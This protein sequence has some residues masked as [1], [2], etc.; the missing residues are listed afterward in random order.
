MLKLSFCLFVILIV[1]WMLHAK[2]VSLVLNLGYVCNVIFEATLYSM[3]MLIRM[4]WVNKQSQIKFLG[5]LQLYPHKQNLYIFMFKV[6]Y[7]YLFMYCSYGMFPDKH[8]WGSIRLTPRLSWAPSLTRWIL[9]LLFQ[10]LL[11]ALLGSGPSRS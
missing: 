9:I 11:I 3:Y 1:S 5:T 4:E 10:A 2:I 8:V 7:S 6:L